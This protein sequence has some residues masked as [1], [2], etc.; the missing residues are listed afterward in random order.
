M[1]LAGIQWQTFRNLSDETVPPFG[2]LRITGANI[3]AD[4]RSY[5]ECRKPDNYGAQWRWAINGPVSVQP[6]EYGACNQSSPTFAVFS[7]DDGDPTPGEAWG[8]KD[9][10]WLIHKYV[11][12]FHV[13]SK[14]QLEGSA[15]GVFVMH[16]PLLHLDGEADED[17]EEDATATVRVMPLVEGV[18]TDRGDTIKA[19][20]YIGGGETIT[21]DTLVVCQFDPNLISEECKGWKIVG[22]R[23][24]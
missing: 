2:V 19:R 14:P 21:E 13:V 10:S 6:N 18:L 7:I 24:Q 5:L 23:C 8:P 17:I 9:G 3:S 22:K 20:E 1:S 15:R 4:G 16:E 12:G 11:G